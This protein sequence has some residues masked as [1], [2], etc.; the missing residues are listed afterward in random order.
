METLLIPLLIL[1]IVVFF[2]DDSNIVEGLK[3]KKSKK[4]NLK[5]SFNKAAKDTYKAT[6]KYVKNSKLYKATGINKYVNMVFGKKKTASP[7]AAP[8]TMT[9]KPAS[10]A[11][12]MDNIIAP[13]DGDSFDLIN[14]DLDE[15]GKALAGNRSNKFVSAA[16][17]GKRYFFNTGVKCTDE[18]TGEVVDR[19]SLVD[20][21]QGVV[22]D[23][24]T[25][26]KSIFAS[27]VADLNRST[28]FKDKPTYK[29][30]IADKC[31]PITIEPVDVY[32]KTL[33]AETQHVSVVDVKNFNKMQQGNNSTEAFSPLTTENMNIGQKAFIYSVSVLGL[34]LLY[35]T[36]RR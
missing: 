34:Y 5:K 36:L 29:E 12:Y 26:D 27:A 24:G 6:T 1:I 3:A 30:T 20:A 4:V 7:V 15:Y 23:D 11:D 22:N 28:I 13:Y 35:K 10:S 8:V 25:I 17:V 14:A 2:F 19:Y 9:L 32:G 31:V 33:K 21:R 16:P 18:K